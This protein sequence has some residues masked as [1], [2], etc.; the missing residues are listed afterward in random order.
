MITFCV[1]TCVF[2]FLTPFCSCWLSGRAGAQRIIDVSARPVWLLQ[3]YR[4]DRRLG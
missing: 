1:L 3:R 2:I 4:A